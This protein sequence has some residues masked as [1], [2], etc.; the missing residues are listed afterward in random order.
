VG[1]G[2]K[3]VKLDVPPRSTVNPT[4]KVE[5]TGGDQ[6]EEE[7]DVRVNEEKEVEEA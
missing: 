2:C 3:W 4:A 7:G 1:G 6:E 5:T